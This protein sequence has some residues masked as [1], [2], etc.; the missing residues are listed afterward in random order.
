MLLFDERP[1]RRFYPVRVHPEFGERIWA[2]VE[3]RFDTAA[4]DE[5]DWARDN[6]KAWHRL[7]HGD[8]VQRLRVI[9][10]KAR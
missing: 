9:R 2:A 1:W 6:L 4:H 8:G 7:C 10:I 5:D 3:E